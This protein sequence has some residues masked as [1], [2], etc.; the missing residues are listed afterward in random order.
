MTGPVLK[1]PTESLNLLRIR[2]IGYGKVSSEKINRKHKAEIEEYQ[3]PGR[4]KKPV[5]MKQ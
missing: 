2:N 3:M 4:V 1:V 5:R